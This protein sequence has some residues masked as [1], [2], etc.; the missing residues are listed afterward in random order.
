MEK[1]IKCPFCGS[2]QVKSTALGYSEKLR[3]E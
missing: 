1:S 3:Q 2:N